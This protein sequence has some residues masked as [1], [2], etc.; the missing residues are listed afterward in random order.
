VVN[1]LILVEKSQKF[2]IRS[3]RGF[4]A[5]IIISPPSMKS[6]RKAVKKDEKLNTYPGSYATFTDSGHV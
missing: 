3:I 4:A 1:E 6:Y 2:F 5:K